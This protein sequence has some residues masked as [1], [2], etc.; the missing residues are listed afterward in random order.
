ML[1]LAKAQQIEFET[2]IMESFATERRNQATR[3]GESTI[4]S[5]SW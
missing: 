1:S 3:S 4:G 5:T 2:E